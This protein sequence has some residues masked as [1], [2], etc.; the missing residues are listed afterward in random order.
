MLGVDVSG[1][2]EACLQDLLSIIQRCMKKLFEVF[3]LWHLLITCL[4]PLSNGLSMV[5]HQLEEGVHQ[6][7]AIWKDT[8]AVQ[9]NR[10]W[11]AVERV[12]VE[13]G[14]DHDERLRQVLSHELMP[15]VGR[16]IGTVIEHLQEW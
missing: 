8:T 4:S 1:H 7:N 15:I 16:L 6:Q 2:G 14:L 5:D 12:R 9:E 13:D 3:I 11:R 10:L